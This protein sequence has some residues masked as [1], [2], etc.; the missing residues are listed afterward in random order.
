MSD[1]PRLD[2]S[3]ISISSLGDDLEETSYWLSRTPEERL[4]AI[5][6]YRRMVYG[7]DIATARLQ[8]SIAVV[9]LKPR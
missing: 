9:E 3:A 5:E 4:S 6:I 7:E 8:R 1:I 2:K